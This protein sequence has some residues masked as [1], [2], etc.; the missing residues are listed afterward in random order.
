[1]DSFNRFR[2]FAASKPAGRMSDYGISYHDPSFPSS[3][4]PIPSRLSLGASTASNGDLRSS[5]AYHHR[6]SD[7]GSRAPP[8]GTESISGL[9]SSRHVD[10]DASAPYTPGH[11]HHPSRYHMGASTAPPGPSS[12]VAAA[13]RA[14]AYAPHAAPAAYTPHAAPA[15]EDHLGA[16]SPDLMTMMTPHP[17]SAAGIDAAEAS[18]HTTTPQ[19]NFRASQ[20]AATPYHARVPRRSSF[21]AGAGAAPPAS[22]SAAGEPFSRTVHLSVWDDLLGLMR[23]QQMAASDLVRLNTLERR[24][25][26]L[27][28]ARMR[29]CARQAAREVQAVEVFAVGQ[30]RAAQA[31]HRGR[32]HEDPGVVAGT[33]TAGS[34]SG[35]GSAS[36][37]LSSRPFA[38]SLQEEWR[39]SLPAA[40]ARRLSARLPSTEERPFRSSFS[41]ISRPSS[42][43]SRHELGL[44]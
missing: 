22:S 21:G 23:E 31:A 30:I 5:M 15:A 17:R 2:D 3:T 13:H 9:H 37:S 33:A 43:A 24:R 4:T 19:T 35:S 34:G 12:S 16:Y 29:A 26:D 44:L 40:P 8:Q 41:S 38:S 1:M 25:T 7:H 18:R 42:S 39:N 28:R 27:L 10:G 20:T 14:S 32:W 11:H 36:A 6:H